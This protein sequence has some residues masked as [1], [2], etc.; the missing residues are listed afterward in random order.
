M[1]LKFSRHIGVAVQGR[2][3][4]EQLSNAVPKL[5]RKKIRGNGILSVVNHNF[6]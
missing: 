5:L 1:L 3:S 4:N 2:V 6:A